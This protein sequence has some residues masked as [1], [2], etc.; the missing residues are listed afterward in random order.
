MFHKKDARLMSPL[1]IIWVLS[2]IFLFFSNLNRKNFK[3]KAETLIRRHRTRRLIWVCNVCLCS[4][5]R[6]DF[7]TSV[8]RMGPFAIIWV[9]GG[10]FLFFSKL[11]RQFFKQKAETLIR[12]HRTR[13]LIW[14]CYVCLCSTKRTLSLYG[15]SMANGENTS[16]CK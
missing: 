14:V 8:S 1:A 16:D 13:R 6:M 4:T 10:N 9:L 7:L 12:R 3:Q 2:G 11:N 5:K 15:L